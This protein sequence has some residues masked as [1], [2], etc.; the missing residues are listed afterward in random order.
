VLPSPTDRQNFVCC[1]LVV[2]CCC[3]CAR[4]TH[5]EGKKVLT[6]VERV[7][8][9]RECRLGFRCRSS[10]CLEKG[11]AGGA[12]SKKWEGGY[13]SVFFFSFFSCLVCVCA[14]LHGVYICRLVERTKKRGKKKEFFFSFLPTESARLFLS[15]LSVCYIQNY[16]THTT[17][18][19]TR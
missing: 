19:Y 9:N 7:K 15:L 6:S 8:S 18:V 12:P 4:R 5:A 10:W 1:V 14:A 13:F 11:W 2:V 16:S 17:T 3:C